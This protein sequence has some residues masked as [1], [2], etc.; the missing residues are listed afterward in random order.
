MIRRPP[1]STLFPYTT[2]FRSPR[3]SRPPSCRSA[4]RSLHPARTRRRPSSRRRSPGELAA[5]LVRAVGRSTR[6]MPP[7]L[8]GPDTG[9]YLWI[10]RPGED[11]M[12]VAVTNAQG[13]LT[14]VIRRAE[15]GEEGVLNRHGRAL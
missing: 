10:V 13:Q 15:A 14:E 1:R 8:T 4:A 5:G 9:P 7:G 3:P 2:L 6:L 12:R 11:R